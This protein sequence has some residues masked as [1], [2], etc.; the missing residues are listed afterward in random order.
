MSTTL[1][2]V[3]DMCSFH[4]CAGGCLVVLA[5]AQNS[6]SSTDQ[7]G[8]SASSSLTNPARAGGSSRTL[9]AYCEP[10]PRAVVRRRRPRTEQQLGAGV[11]ERRIPRLA[12]PL[13]RRQSGGGSELVNRSAG[14]VGTYG[15]DEPS[16]RAAAPLPQRGVAE[17]EFSRQVRSTPSATDV[18]QVERDQEGLLLGG[19][20]P[21][22]HPPGDDVQQVGVSG[23]AVNHVPEIL[24]RV[25]RE[26]VRDF[27][28]VHWD[29]ARW[30]A[31]AARELVQ[32][33][34]GEVA[35]DRGPPPLRWVGV[36]HLPEGRDGGPRSPATSP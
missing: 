36:K 26:P 33:V 31:T 10:T 12:N 32:R 34:Q 16:A 21:G 20:D 25:R 3:A 4:P 8:A 15:G 22:A 7:P 27:L 35:G 18:R 23:Q 1:T 5:C 14:D 17:P 29:V 19:D 2:S 28:G 13:R 6:S 24:Q 11:V 30:L 9:P